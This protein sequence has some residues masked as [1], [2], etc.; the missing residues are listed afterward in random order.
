MPLSVLSYA[1]MIGIFS[2]LLVIFVLFYDG[3]TKVEA[4]GSLWDPAA[5]SWEPA[6]LGKM[7]VAFGLF[8]AG[9]RK[10]LQ[11]AEGCSF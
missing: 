11:I 8:M 2:T 9:V 3:L 1:S 7:G 4:P 5:T 10:S 6:S